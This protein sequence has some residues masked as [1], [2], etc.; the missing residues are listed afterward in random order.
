MD[1]LQLVAQLLQS[2]Q[3]H[4]ALLL[5]VRTLL[6]DFFELNAASCVLVAQR[7]SFFAFL[8]Q[9]IHFFLQGG[10]FILK[11]SCFERML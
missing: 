11:R 6:L 3:E 9:G 2:E 5:P 8:S 1:N 7:V 10:N 4:L